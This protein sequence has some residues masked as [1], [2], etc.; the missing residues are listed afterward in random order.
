MVPKNILRHDMEEIKEEDITPEFIETLESDLRLLESREKEL[1]SLVNEL[2][3]VESQIKDQSNKLN[4]VDQTKTPIPDGVI[5]LEEK[6]VWGN[7]IG[8]LKEYIHN[9][10]MRT[11]LE[12]DLKALTTRQKKVTAKIIKIVPASVRYYSPQI[13]AKQFTINVS[14]DRVTI[15]R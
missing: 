14:D 10:K 8:E 1:T 11:E 13:N 12:H 9:K 7:F 3:T 2:R 5:S 15:I 4:S 6:P